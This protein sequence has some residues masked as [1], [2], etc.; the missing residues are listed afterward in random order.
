MR[1]KN[2][3]PMANGQIKKDKFFFSAELKTFGK[4]SI[5]KSTNSPAKHPYKRAHS[6]AIFIF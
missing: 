4:S 1:L 5:L 3:W 6:V 2:Q